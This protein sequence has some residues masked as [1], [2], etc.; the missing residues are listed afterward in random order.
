M[1]LYYPWTTV[2]HTNAGDENFNF[3]LSQVDPDTGIMPGQWYLVR[4]HFDTSVVAE[5]AGTHLAEGYIRAY[6]DLDWKMMYRWQ[7]GQDYLPVVDGYGRGGTFNWNLKGSQRPDRQYGHRSIS[8]PTTLANTSANT[9]NMRFYMSDF[10]MSAG[11]NSGG[12]GR[13]DLPVYNDY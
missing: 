12:N 4:L 7:N 8:W 2:G 11:P 5:S 10:A 1:A 6:G 3:K 13:D 9:G